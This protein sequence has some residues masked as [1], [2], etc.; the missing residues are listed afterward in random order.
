MKGSL[1]LEAEGC[2]L[3]DRAARRRKRGKREREKGSVRGESWK[4]GTVNH[5]ELIRTHINRP[6][7]TGFA[8]TFFDAVLTSM[9]LI[10]T[11][12][13][14][15]SHSGCFWKGSPDE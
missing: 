4:E 2:I 1:D 9:S 8:T 7:R 6:G 13:Q 10:T 11:S 15:L 12:L 3:N 14:T 5:H